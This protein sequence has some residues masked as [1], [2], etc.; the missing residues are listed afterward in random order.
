MSDSIII[1]NN[2]HECSYNNHKDE[3]SISIYS[4]KLLNPCSQSQRL[5]LNFILLLLI[6]AL[7]INNIR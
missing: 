2:S 1:R 4:A 7:F 6:F 3:T 5:L